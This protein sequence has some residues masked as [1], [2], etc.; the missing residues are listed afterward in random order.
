MCPVSGHVPNV[1]RLV[2]KDLGKSERDMRAILRFQQYKSRRKAEKMSSLVRTLK[3]AVSSGKEAETPS[4]QG[5]PAALNQTRSG[6]IAAS[7]SFS[8]FS[9]STHNDG[10]QELAVSRALAAFWT[11]HYPHRHLDNRKWINMVVRNRIQGVPDSI[12]PC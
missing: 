5:L 10:E 7:A 3:R 2:T 4:A 9:L 8:D 12:Q 6:G 11:P 1:R